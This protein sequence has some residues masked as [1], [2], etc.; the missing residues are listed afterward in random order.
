MHTSVDPGTLL[1]LERQPD[2][3]AEDLHVLHV[4]V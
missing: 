2:G 1:T 3:L 4:L